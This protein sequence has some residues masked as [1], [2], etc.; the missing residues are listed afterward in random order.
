MLI[1]L[2]WDDHVHNQVAINWLAENHKKGWATCSITQLGFAR[3]SSNKAFVKNAVSTNQAID[4]LL[5]IIATPN[6]KFWGEPKLGLTDKIMENILPKLLRHEQLTDGFLVGIA[7]K[8]GGKLAT[9][10]RA[11]CKLFPDYTI[12]VG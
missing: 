4:K 11:L 8:N 9:L 3:L 10:D 5:E 2:G 7:K 6:H 1:A 12:L